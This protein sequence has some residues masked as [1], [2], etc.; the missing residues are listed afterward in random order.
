[1]CWTSRPSV[2]CRASCHGGQAALSAARGRQAAG[3]ADRRRRP[4]PDAPPGSIL[5]DVMRLQPLLGP[6]IDRF[7]APTMRSTICPR[8]HTPLLAVV[9]ALVGACGPSR[10][11]AD[12]V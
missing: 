8:F 11:L 10:P 2:E 12:A 1:M 4:G 6:I 5:L 7:W 3:P 9:L